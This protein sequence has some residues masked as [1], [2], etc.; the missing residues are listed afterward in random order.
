MNR[1]NFEK[2]IA[3]FFVVVTFLR[4]VSCFKETLY[5]GNSLI[6]R[7]TL[8]FLPNFRIVLGETVA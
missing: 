4:H 6:N 5:L 8:I 1:Y 3:L 2:N 7:E